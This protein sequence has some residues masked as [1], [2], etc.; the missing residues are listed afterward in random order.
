VSDKTRIIELQKSL[1][2]ARNALEKI[3][4]GHSRDPQLDALNA[5]D[6]M[7][8]LEPK[9]QLQGVVGHAR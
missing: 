2:F 6:E 8:R 4:H 1:K 5:L 7:H 9:Q 3:G